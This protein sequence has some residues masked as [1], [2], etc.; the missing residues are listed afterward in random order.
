MIAVHR[1]GLLERERH[2]QLAAWA[3]DCAERVLPLFEAGRADDRPRRAMD[4]A[5]AW[6]RGEVPVGAA[7]K[8]S[9]A[10]HAAARAADSPAAVA[11]ARAAGHAVATA[12]MADHSLGAALYALKALKMAGRPTGAERARQIR[13]LPAGLRTTVADGLG[14][15][16][17]ILTG[18]RPATP[19]SR[20]S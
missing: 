7:Q 8:A 17:A 9:V 4:V 14:R 1:G 16:Q 13:R 5:R 3:A 6:A 20:G 11:A 12:H 15:K 19:S 10:A 18:R 2:R